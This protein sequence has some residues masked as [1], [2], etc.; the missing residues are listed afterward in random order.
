M[1]SRMFEVMGGK[2]GATPQ[3]RQMPHE[4]AQAMQEDY[5]RFMARQDRSTN[6]NAMIEEGLRLGRFSRQQVEMAR[7]LA[8][9]YGAMLTGR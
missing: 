9:Q 4:M 6:P 3:M 1:P 8:D 7:R 2:T 5:R